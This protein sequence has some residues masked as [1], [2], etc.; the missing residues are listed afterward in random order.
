MT[1]LEKE[2]QEDLMWAQSVLDGHGCD[3][4]DPTAAC[5]MLSSLNQHGVTSEIRSAASNT[6]LN[7]TPQVA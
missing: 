2:Q 6:L 3:C 7:Y 4:D 5:N 1:T